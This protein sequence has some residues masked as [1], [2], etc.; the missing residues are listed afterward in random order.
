MQFSCGGQRVLEQHGN[1]H[2]PDTTRHREQLP[3]TFWRAWLGMQGDITRKLSF[4][5][6]VGYG[7]VDFGEGGEEFDVS[8]IGGLLGQVEFS[9]RP[10]ITQRH[11]GA[12]RG[13]GSTRRTPRGP[14]HGTQRPGRGVR[15]T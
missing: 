3:G 13:A 12:R 9:L 14:S 7:N 2:R 5:G 10:A 1:C 11:A 8:G 4:M 15:A 6:L